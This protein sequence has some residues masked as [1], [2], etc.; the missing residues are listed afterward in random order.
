M[1]FVHI[2][3]EFG[4]CLDCP[5]ADFRLCF[6]YFLFQNSLSMVWD[7]WE[8]V[9]VAMSLLNTKKKKHQKMKNYLKLQKNTIHSDKTLHSK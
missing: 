9:H 6:F 5:T 3:M 7:A 1:T 8:W 4:A 2:A